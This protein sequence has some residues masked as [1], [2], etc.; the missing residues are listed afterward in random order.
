MPINSTCRFAVKVQQL[1]ARK[2]LVHY[3]LAGQVNP[4]PAKELGTTRYRR[5]ELP[6]P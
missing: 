2:L 3:N 6:L 4:H 1:L 5:L